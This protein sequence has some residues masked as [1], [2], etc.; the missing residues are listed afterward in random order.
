MSLATCGYLVVSL[1]GTMRRRKDEITAISV[2]PDGRLS[3]WLKEHRK[4]LGISQTEAGKRAGMSRTQWTRLELGESG[5]RREN[6]PN[7]AKAVNADLAE[8]Y[9]RAG[10]DPPQ[11][12]LDP[13]GFDGS[14][15]KFLFQQHERLSKQGKEKFKAVLEM[16]RNYLDQLE[17]EGDRK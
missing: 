5:T 9:K 12:L 7:I 16:V 17:Q 10:F 6:V 4:R 14:E 13:A 8:T 11:E 2:R 3:E 15:F 1:Y